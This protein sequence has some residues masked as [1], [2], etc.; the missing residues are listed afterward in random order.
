MHIGGVKSIAGV[1]STAI[2][3]K[4]TGLESDIWNRHKPYNVQSD[5]CIAG[6]S[7]RLYWCVLDRQR[8]SWQMEWV[9]PLE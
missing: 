6:N 9:G 2:N 8:L 1:S 3:L 7:S 5:Y 4:L